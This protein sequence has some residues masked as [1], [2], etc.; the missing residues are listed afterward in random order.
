MATP[1][2]L[3]TPTSQVTPTVLVTPTSLVTP[4]PTLPLPT[5][6]SAAFY[7]PEASAQCALPDKHLIHLTVYNIAVF[8]ETFWGFIYQDAAIPLVLIQT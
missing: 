7:G 3:T 8:N 6:C 1:T 2:G 5:R 4:T